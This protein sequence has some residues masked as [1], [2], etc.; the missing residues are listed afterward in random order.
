MQHEGKYCF[1]EGMVQCEDLSQQLVPSVFCGQ[2]LG[3]WTRKD[4]TEQKEQ[5][6]EKGGVVLTTTAVLRDKIKRDLEK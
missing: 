1:N 3:L 6:K 2:S 4:I 5:H